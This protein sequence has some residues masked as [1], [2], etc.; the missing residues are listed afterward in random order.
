MGQARLRSKEIAELKAQGAKPKTV[1]VRTNPDEHHVTAFGA[2]YHD[3]EYDGIGIYLNESFEPS[4]GWTNLTFHTLK[5]LVREE[6]L[7]TTPG[8]KTERI[9]LAWTNLRENIKQYNQLIFKTPF[10]QMTGS[11]MEADLT[12]DL[13]EIFI[14]AITN[15]WYLQQM[16]E[17]PDDDYNG[18]VIYRRP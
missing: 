14:Y 12:D 9:E 10:R 13:I 7:S 1:I 2:Y 8:N 3:N 16:G 18:M 15:I 6:V 4:P 11:P 5:D 17:I